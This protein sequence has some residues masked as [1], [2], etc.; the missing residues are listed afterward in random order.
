[1]RQ[2]TE[3]QWQK[4]YDTYKRWYNT[5]SKNNQMVGDLLTKKEF[6]REYQANARAAEL[7]G[8]K[9]TN[10]ARTV[11]M[12]QMSLSQAQKRV[13]YQATK[14][15]GVKQSL[16]DVRQAMKEIGLS[17]RQA[18]ANVR[19]QLYDL[20]PSLRPPKAY[21]DMTPEERAA[22]KPRRQRLREAFGDRLYHK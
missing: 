15:Q 8:R 18:Y 4:S 7:E 10:P 20:D 1:M 12:D 19:E 22:D 21:K 9:Q 14:P 3:A 2:K 17:G 5:Y 6:K 16:S 11:A 13:I